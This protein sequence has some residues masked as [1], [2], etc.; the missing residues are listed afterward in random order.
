[1]SSYIGSEH[2]G[3][4]GLLIVTRGG[5]VVLKVVCGCGGDHVGDL[6]VQIA[7]K[8]IITALDAWREADRVGFGCQRCR[9]AMDGQWTVVDDMEPLPDDYR[10][11]FGDAGHN[12]RANDPDV[13]SWTFSFDLKSAEVV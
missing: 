9:V 4:R 10:A 12:P 11:G 2:I 6:S 7:K 3:A 1:M 8:N 13:K 5:G